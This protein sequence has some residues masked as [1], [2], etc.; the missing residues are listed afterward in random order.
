[1]SLL[2][3]RSHSRSSRMIFTNSDWNPSRLTKSGGGKRI[4]KRFLGYTHSNFKDPQ[5]VQ[6]WRTQ[7][8]TRAVPARLPTL[9]WMLAAGNFS[10]NATMHWHSERCSQIICWVFITFLGL[11]IFVKMQLTHTF[12]SMQKETIG[13]PCTVFSWYTFPCALVKDLSYST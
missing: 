4:G 13:N 10:F 1:M 12:H 7:T 9:R 3:L 6:E 11:I 5:N 8:E 2:C